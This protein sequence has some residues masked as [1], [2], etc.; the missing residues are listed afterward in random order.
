M[1]LM[2]SALCGKAQNDTYYAKQMQK[3][4]DSGFEPMGMPPL[5]KKIVFLESGIQITTGNNSI[6]L[7]KYN[8]VNKVS[9]KDG[10]YRYEFVFDI[11]DVALFFVQ[12]PYDVG[13]PKL[14]FA[15]LKIPEKGIRNEGKS[16][17]YRIVFQ[18]FL[19]IKQ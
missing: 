4:V 16:E 2:I 9:L 6:Y 19:V 10:A 17:Y 1:I 5:F 13:P 12:L 3:E 18:D 11:G 14:G 7:L 15:M 8:E